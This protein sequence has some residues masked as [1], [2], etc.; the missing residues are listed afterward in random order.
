MCCTQP[1]TPKTNGKAERFIQTSLREWAGRFAYAHQG[2]ADVIELKG[3]D[4]G[5]DQFH[6]NTLARW[7]RPD[8]AR[9]GRRLRSVLSRPYCHL[10]F[11][12]NARA[13]LS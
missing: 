3:F 12:Y 2:V 8:R 10:T 9:G 7:K 11:P 4:D 5:D 6:Y 1:Y 13:S